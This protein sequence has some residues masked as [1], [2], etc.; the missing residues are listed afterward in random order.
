MDDKRKQQLA[1]QLARKPAAM[2]TVREFLQYQVWGAEPEDVQRS[3]VGLQAVNPYRV[4]QIIDALEKVAAADHP[5]G[6]LSQLVMIDG[7]QMLMDESD[8]GAR[9]WL[10]ELAAQMRGWTTGPAGT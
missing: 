3:V 4:T 10:R 8:D 1:E 9:A 5:A 6:T 7:N 2:D